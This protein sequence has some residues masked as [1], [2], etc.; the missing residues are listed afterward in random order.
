LGR[1]GSRI[2]AAVERATSIGVQRGLIVGGP[3]YTLPNS[4]VVIRDRS[5]VASATLRKTEML[6]PAEID[7]S[8]IDIVDANFGAGVDDLIQASARALGYASTSSQLRATLSA[9]V[10]RLLADG[11]LVE[12]AG[13]L[14]RAR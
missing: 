4:V 10:E 7:K 12:K 13:M 8:L 6:P 5:A 11:N 2:R 1:A 3:F 9:G 14:V